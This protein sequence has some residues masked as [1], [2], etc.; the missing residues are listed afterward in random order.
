MG[1]ENAG[2]PGPRTPRGARATAARRRAREDDII[3]AT[4]HLFDTVGL[5]DAQIEDI[6]QSVGINRAIIY[7]HFSGKEELFALTLV[8][9]L[10]ELAE[11]MRDADDESRIPA[12]RLE[13]VASAFLDRG[14]EHPAFVDCA[15]DLLS[16]SGEELFESVSEGAMIRL[17]RGMLGPLGVLAEVLEAGN[18]SG[19]F[20]V[21]DPYMLANMLYTQ[22]LGALQFARNQLLVSEGAPGVPTVRRVSWEAVKRHTI[23]AAHAMAIADEP[24]G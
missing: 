5:R 2:A 13:R 24:V 7:R 18:K 9:Y 21:D 12:E 10:D 20:H 1:D 3:R 6:A 17:G 11:V 22:S 16:K 23:R 19:D 8:G 14:H 15:L 4:R